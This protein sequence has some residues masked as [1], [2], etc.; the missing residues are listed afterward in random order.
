[1][2][3]RRRGFLHRLLLAG[4]N[5]LLL[6]VLVILIG[7]TLQ[8]TGERLERQRYP[9]P[10]RLVEVGDGMHIHLR[11]WG[12]DNDGPAI[13]FD[14]S[15]SYFSSV[16]AWYGEMLGDRYRVVAYDRPGMGWSVGRQEPRDARTA[17]AA[18]SAA[19]ERA[20]I[21]PPY[22]VAGHSYGGFSARVF[23][24]LHRDDLAGLILLDS[25][26]PDQGGGPYYGILYRLRAWAAHTGLHV[27][28]PL[29]NE[30]ASLP[31]D[32]A[33]RA[34]AV[35]RWTS[36]LDATAEEL[37]AFDV[38]AEQVRQAGSFDDTPLLVVSAAGSANHLA[39][40]RDLTRLSSRGE[41]VHLDHV[42]HVSMLLRQEHATDVVA[43]IRRFLADVVH[44]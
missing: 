13:I 10:G 6:V 24:G 1:V 27:L 11:T 22:V 28:L 44:R 34:H 4:R 7:A 37:E 21:G 38:S 19:L 17:A 26:H 32:E 2:T 35:S 43:E 33:P 5:V 14:A 29:P 40:Q 36:H 31:P 12:M 30:M 23:A 15:G 9:P 41:L 18:L 42:Y 8:A 39:L 3:L 20:G 25:S 16:F